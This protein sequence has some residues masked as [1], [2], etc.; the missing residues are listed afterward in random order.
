VYF[1]DDFKPASVDINKMATVDVGTNHQVTVTVP[2]LDSSGTEHTIFK[3]SQRP[4]QKECV[5]IID[6]VTGEMK[7]EKL[8]GNIQVK[9]TRKE[10]MKLGV[11][12][13]PGQ[14]GLPSLGDP[15]EK[16]PGP[17]VRKTHTS[18]SRVPSGGSRQKLKPPSVISSKSGSIPHHSPLPPSPSYLSPGHHQSP[19][20]SSG[21]S[22][23]VPAHQSS[24]VQ[25]ASLPSLMGIDDFTA[26]M[27]TR[28]KESPD[29]VQVSCI[30]PC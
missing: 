26:S 3:G 9:K 19:P 18:A 12:G 22:L 14:L 28:P 15:I 13:K 21:S 8:S 4:Y 27:D 29:H 1:S 2:H 6:H 16:L 23:S 30:S 5:L 20:G 25:A 11:P 17:P 10:S 7:L 24:P